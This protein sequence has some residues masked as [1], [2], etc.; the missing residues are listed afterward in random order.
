MNGVFY[1]PKPLAELLLKHVVPQ[2]NKVD[3]LLEPSVGA[4]VFIEAALNILKKVKITAIDIDLE[5]VSRLKKQTSHSFICNDFLKEDFFEDKFDLVIGNP[6]YIA[7]KNIGEEARAY[8]RVLLSS[9]GLKMTTLNMWGLFLVRAE[10]LVTDK[11]ALAFVLPSDI[12]ETIGGNNLLKYLLEKFDRI[13]L[14]DI[15]KHFF[16]EVEQDTILFCAYRNHQYKGLFSGTICSEGKSIVVTE[17]IS[18]IF[19]KV[20]KASL[21]FPNHEFAEIFSLY[22]KM[23]KVGDYC[24]TSPGI[25]TAA[26]NFFILPQQKAQQLAVDKKEN[27]IVPKGYVVNGQLNLTERFFADMSESGTPCYLLNLNSVE[28]LPVQVK[29][30]LEVGESLGLHNRYK[31]QSRDPW[32]RLPSVWTSECVFFKRTHLFPKLLLNEEKFLVTDAAYRIN[33]IRDACK[34]SFMYS[35]YNSFTL[36]FAEILGRKYAGGVLELTPSEFRKLPLPYTKCSQ[37]D[38]E[39][40]KT[41]FNSKETIHDVLKLYDQKTLY[42]YISTDFRDRV[43]SSYSKLISKRLQLSS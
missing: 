36:L 39:F 29:D 17:G 31:M 22:E 37:S 25:V 23:P 18:L 9:S 5:P 27:R 16:S 15:P 35:F 1:T 12:R 43:D 7:W 21:S 8:A 6:P 14:V 24:T 26:N 10:Q 38:F 11:G 40:F 20:G 28:E 34:D 2:L 13:E 19:S 42:T 30:Y 4:G 32:Y 3:S 41:T 33:F